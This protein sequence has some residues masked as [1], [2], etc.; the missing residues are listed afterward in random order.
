MTDM[1]DYSQKLSMTTSDDGIGSQM[2]ASSIPSLRSLIIQSTPS[3]QQSSSGKPTT[4]VEG[5]PLHEITLCRGKYKLG[6]AC[7]PNVISLMNS[8]S[9]PIRQDTITSLQV[10]L[11][12]H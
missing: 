8:L 5:Q 4:I 3:S 9:E 10:S 11:I 6:E 12:I 1:D 2:R 7:G